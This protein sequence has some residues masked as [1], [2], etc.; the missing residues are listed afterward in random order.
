VPSNVLASQIN[1]QGLIV[2]TIDI[3][4]SLKAKLDLPTCKVVF[5]RDNFIDAEEGA[6]LE[7][8]YDFDTE[9]T[10]ISGSWIS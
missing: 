2:Q 10:T 8:P 7:E 9:A 1:Y 6:L 3:K 4:E 5:N